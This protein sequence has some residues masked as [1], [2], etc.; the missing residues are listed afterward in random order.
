MT[1]CERFQFFYFTGGRQGVSI[2]NRRRRPRQAV[3]APPQSQNPTTPLQIDIPDEALLEIAEDFENT[4]KNYHHFALNNKP[5]ASY[6]NTRPSSQNRQLSGPLKHP[7]NQI[8]GSEHALTKK[9][10]LEQGNYFGEKNESIFRQ[11]QTNP[12]SYS[13]TNTR[14]PFS[15]KFESSTK[16]T[17]S[18]VDKYV[19]AQSL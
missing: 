12:A 13:I 11:Q 4:P 5:G 7:N 15:S 16:R 14:N 3:Y 9:P 10:K 2:F 8:H 1:L 6:Q 17:F 19:G 18:F